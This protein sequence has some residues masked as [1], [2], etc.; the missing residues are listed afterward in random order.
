MSKYPHFSVIDKSFDY[1]F[2]R[3]FISLDPTHIT[4]PLVTT[5]STEPSLALRWISSVGV[6]HTTISLICMSTHKATA[7]RCLSYHQATSGQPA[8]W[9]LATAPLRRLALSVLF[10]I[11]TTSYQTTCTVSERSS[12]N[13][14]MTWWQ[15]RHSLEGR[16]MWVF[17]SANCWKKRPVRAKQPRQQ[18]SSL[19]HQQHLLKER[20]Q[21]RTSV[22]EY[23]VHAARLCSSPMREGGQ[24][25]CIQGTIKARQ[26]GQVALTDNHTET[27]NASLGERGHCH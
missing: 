16:I 6:S 4:F 10:T 13:G 20:A 2:N 25:N 17:H 1:F 9:T 11:M 15:L 3:C 23:L 19:D 24:D 14:I 12:I 27:R 22:G 8:I 7:A 5:A 18:D 26:Q 21:D